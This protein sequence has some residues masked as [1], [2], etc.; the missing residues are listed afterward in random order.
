MADVK[1]LA[2]PAAVDDAGQVAALGLEAHEVVEGAI[3]IGVANLEALPDPH[4]RMVRE[5]GDAVSIV[6]H[7]AT[8]FFG[9]APCSRK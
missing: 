5:D 1:V 9:H 3:A 8:S 2:P 6:L 7:H 4:P